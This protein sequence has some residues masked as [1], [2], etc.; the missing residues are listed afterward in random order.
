MLKK[1]LATTY[2]KS[3]LDMVDLARE[4]EELESFAE[5]F[6][7]E[8]FDNN[9]RFASV[10]NEIKSGLDNRDAENVDDNLGRT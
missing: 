2:D 10:I 3:D 9:P 8:N 5:K 4:F 7:G 1:N 6:S